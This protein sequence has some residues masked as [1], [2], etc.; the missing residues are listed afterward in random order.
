MKILLVHNF[1]Q[2]RGGEDE[3]VE[4]EKALLEKYGNEIVTYYVDSS[5]IKEYSNIQ[6][7]LVLPRTVYNRKHGLAVV[8]KAKEI[9]ADIVHIH[10]FWPLISPSIFFHLNRANIPYVQ[11]VH[12]FRYTV[13][14]ALLNG[15][16][17]N[18]SAKELTIQK[19]PL[20]SFKSSYLMTFI[21]WLTARLVRWSKVLCKGS[22]ALLFLNSFGLEVH[23]HIFP[24]VRA[25]TKGN[26]L[27]NRDIYKVSDASQCDP[28]FL[29]LGRCSEEKGIEVLLKSY[30]ESR[31]KIKLKIAGTGPLLEKLS[32]EYADKNIEFIG[33]VSGEEKAKVIAGAKVLIIPSI[34]LETFGLTAIEAAQYDVP[35]VASNNGGLLS[36]IDDKQ[37]GLLFESG[38]VKDLS[39]KLQW[40]ESHPEDLRIMGEQARLYAE[41]H[42]SEEK[43]YEQLMAIYQNLIASVREG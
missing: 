36:L 43:N 11:T 4:N 17:W 21:Y 42:F 28:Y 25:Y 7:A 40:C 9:N 22:G 19:R 38:S 32:K 16:D 8:Q 39:E 33:F 18:Q 2:Y 41:E 31:I 15:A 37:N 13:A 14:N 29:F 12:N 6:K 23:K 35:S 3:V 34:V 30:C 26:Y 10:N 27:P 1:Y 24:G 20:N 5:E